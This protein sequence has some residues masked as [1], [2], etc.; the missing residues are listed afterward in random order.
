[1]RSGVDEHEPLADTLRR[2]HSDG[3]Y[4][5]ACANPLRQ[6]PFKYALYVQLTV[7]PPTFRLPQRYVTRT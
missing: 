1:L 2:Q 3:D 7:L 5:R 4:R 6:I